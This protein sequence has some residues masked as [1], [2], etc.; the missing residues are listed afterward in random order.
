MVEFD[1]EYFNSG[2]KPPEPFGEELKKLGSAIETQFMA[3][4]ELFPWVDKFVTLENFE[5]YFAY[6]FM[7]KYDDEKE[8]YI[9]HPLELPKDQEQINEYMNGYSDHIESWKEVIQLLKLTPE[10]TDEIFGGFWE[11]IASEMIQVEI[12]TSV[13]R[14][15]TYAE[16]D[17][18]GVDPFRFIHYIA[19]RFLLEDFQLLIR[20]QDESEEVD[21]IFVKEISEVESEGV[22]FLRDI[23][24]RKP[25]VPTKPIH[26]A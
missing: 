18:F 22:S 17:L 21:A 25:L 20:S 12:S 11:E 13:S 19:P 3:F 7:A 9:Y 1:N 6:Q 5:A 15:K 26:S 23:L 10:Q 16:V 14:Q 4:K 2:V 8:E 24:D